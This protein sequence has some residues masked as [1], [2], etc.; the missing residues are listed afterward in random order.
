LRK[1]SSHLCKNFCGNCLTPVSIAAQLAGNFPGAA[2][3]N[4]V[5]AGAKKPKGHVFDNGPLKA[6]RGRGA[7]S[8][9][10]QVAYEIWTTRYREVA[11]TSSQRDSKT[12]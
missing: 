8:K 10:G 5:R 6:G 9:T 1:L 3:S 4:N 7:A 11:L 12:F 2:I